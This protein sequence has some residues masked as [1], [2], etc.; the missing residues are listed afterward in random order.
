M[1]KS[2]FPVRA[3]NPLVTRD[4]LV[5]EV[6]SWKGT[7]FH[8]QASLKGHG[9]DCR[10][11]ITGVGR[12]LGLPEAELLAAT[13]RTYRKDFRPDLMLERLRAALIPVQQGLPG[14]VVAIQIDRTDD[15]PRHLAML[16]TGDRLVHCYGGGPLK[17][18]I[19]VP[20][21]RSRPIHSFWTWP[22][23]GG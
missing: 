2:P 20:I 13:E 11:L 8:W 4:Q 18:V 19:E 22:S 17:K 23:L 5:A 9:C 1:S 3:V 6:R 12:E 16:T 15:G 10:G 7:P 21:G 14:D